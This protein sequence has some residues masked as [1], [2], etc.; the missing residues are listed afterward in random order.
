MN[1]AGAF[2]EPERWTARANEIWL[3]SGCAQ[4][5]G[6]FRKAHWYSLASE[7]STPWKEPKVPDAHAPHVMVC[8]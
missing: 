4:S 3:P 5:R 7:E 1:R 6:A 8:S 2:L